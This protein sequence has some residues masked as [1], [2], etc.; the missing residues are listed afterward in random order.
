MLQL[1]SIFS[2]LLDTKKAY[3]RLLIDMKKV[4]LKNVFHII[5]KHLSFSLR[6]FSLWQIVGPPWKEEEIK[7]GVDNVIF[8]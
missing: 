5:S 1:D 7:L 4:L 6:K 2:F 8:V 3:F